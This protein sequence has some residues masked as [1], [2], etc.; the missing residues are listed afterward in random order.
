MK[1]TDTLVWPLTLEALDAQAAQLERDKI[2]IDA[3]IDT[4]PIPDGTP[5]RSHIFGDVFEAERYYRPYC[6][7]FKSAQAEVQ[8]KIEAHEIEIIRH[9]V[10]LCGWNTEGRALILPADYVEAKRRHRELEQDRGTT[11]RAANQLQGQR[12]LMEKALAAIERARRWPPTEV[13]HMNKLR[14]VLD[15]FFRR[16]W[17]RDLPY[18]CHGHPFYTA[19]QYEAEYQRPTNTL[20]LQIVLK[21]VP[22]S[23]VSARA[24]AAPTDIVW[25]MR[26][27]PR[28]MLVFDQNNSLLDPDVYTTE[29]PQVV[30]VIKH[31]IQTITR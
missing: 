17:P 5:I 26:D 18:C 28:K 24:I 15:E 29:I 2:E 1:H 25:G 19:E 14:P 7:D 16:P 21:G 13:K 20:A 30:R 22:L 27:V 8:R 10:N 23:L 9:P 11:W 3:Q 6:V 31:H 12:R 4:T